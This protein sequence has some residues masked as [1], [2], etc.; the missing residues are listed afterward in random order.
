MQR[1]GKGFSEVETP[2]FTGMLVEQQVAE[3]GDAEVHGEEVSAVNTTEGDATTAHGEVPT[4]NAEP[5][6]PSSTP[7]TLLPQASHD[8][9]STS[10]GRMIAEMDQDSDVVL[11]DDKEKDETKPAEV[12]EVVNIV[13]TAKLITE[14][15]AID[16][17]K[18]KA[19]ED[20]AVKRYQVLKRKPQTKAQARKNMMVYLKKVVGFKMNYFEGMSYDDIRPIF[21]RYFD[22]NMDFLQKTKEQK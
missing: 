11:E 21:E 6:S 13:A 10:Q 14:D 22:S 4:A 3:E 12:Q 9:H 2:L 7:P 1:V 15:E 19:K 5:S 16:H 20:P 18:R 17:V 8:I